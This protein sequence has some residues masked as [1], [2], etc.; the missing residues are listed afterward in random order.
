MSNN[1]LTAARARQR[2]KNASFTGDSGA[3]GDGDRGAWQKV[4]IYSGNPNDTTNYVE[5]WRQLIRIYET[6]WEARKIVRIPVEDALRKQWQI[7]NIPEPAIKILNKALERLNFI[8]TLSRSLMLERL[9]GG[10][11]SF[12]GLEANEDKP[13]KIYHP[14]EG[15]KLRFINAVPVSRISRAEWCTDPLSV[16]YMRPEKFMVNGK[17]VHVSRCLVWDGEPLFDPNDFALTYYRANIS[18]FGPSK[19]IPIWDDI[20]KAV[21]TRQAAYQLIQTN[22][23][24]IAAVQDL[25]DLSGTNPGKANL[26]KIR[27]IAQNLSVYRATIIDGEKVNISQQGASFGSVPELLLVFIQ[28]LSAASDIP[29]TRFL[30]QAPGGLNATGESDLENYYNTIDSYQKRRIE[31][32]V[33]RVCDIIGYNKIP[34]WEKLRDKIE[35]T[36]PP[37]WN[38]SE[39][40]EADLH[41][42]HIDNALKLY[43]QGL[44]SDEKLLQEINAKKALTIDLDETDISVAEE[45]EIADPGTT[46]LQREKGTGGQNEA[47]GG[48]LR[49]E[50]VSPREG[51]K[52]ARESEFRRLFNVNNWVLLIAK[53]GGDPHSIKMS[54]FVEGMRIEKEHNDITHG[55][56]VKTAKIVLAHLKEV[57]DYYTKLE[58]YVEPEKIQNIIKEEDGKFYVYSH[59]GKKKLSKGGT[60]AEAEKRLQQ[61]EYFKHQN[62]LSVD[63]KID[64]LTNPQ[65]Q[66]TDGQKL[67]GNYRKYHIEYAGIPIA[68]ENPKGTIRSNGDWETIMQADYGYIKKIEGNDGDRL[69]V[70]VGNIDDSP[71]CF[72][73]DQINPK[74]GKFDEHKVFLGFGGIKQARQVY[75]DSF[76]D[77]NPEKRIMSIVSI[78]IDYFKDW[79]ENGDMSLPFS[80][81]Q[82]IKRTRSK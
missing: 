61:I 27:E 25:Q 56:E 32:A 57:P 12:L 47:Q 30:G 81:P 50:G 35:I 67:A 18:G 2:I 33:R 17:N 60:K 11:L 41:A 37:L 15:A 51:V 3:L 66:P 74:T 13:E 48:V 39:L 5:R 21:G 24:I 55:D 54:E 69:D 79:L 71:V 75:L 23:A 7:E 70:F 28:V 4:P 10:C 36:F 82:P 16:H 20:V 6:S 45:S 8:N 63:D 59:D 64:L 26:S 46:P 65:I 14:H 34:G 9:L 77:N 49:S 44:I 52:N 29:A 42:K 19:L 53:A 22:N 40:E 58:E 76:S 31:P 73:L 43:E 80:M 68:I 72:V 78:H 62:S 38:L 1:I